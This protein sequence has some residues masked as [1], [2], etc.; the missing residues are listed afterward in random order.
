MVRL[1]FFYVYSFLVR[2]YFGGLCS[3]LWCLLYCGGYGAVDIYFF[4]IDLYKI[5]T[6]DRCVL[7]IISKFLVLFVLY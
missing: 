1:N 4:L 3:V 7:V 5:N 6:G 2:G